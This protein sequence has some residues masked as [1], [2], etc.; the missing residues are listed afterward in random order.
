MANGR[1]D[2][3]VVIVI[4]LVEIALLLSAASAT[5]VKLAAKKV[6]ATCW[7]LQAVGQGP[8]V[9]EIG[10]IAPVVANSVNA[11]HQE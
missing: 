10:V 1:M 7:A 3:F 9:E 2:G 8:P 6:A 5:L 11:L 4:V